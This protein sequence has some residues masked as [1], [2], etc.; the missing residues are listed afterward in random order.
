MADYATLLDDEI[1]AFIA[2]TES[3][4]P[5]DAVTLSIGEQRRVYDEMCRAFESGAPP[6]VT[7]ADGRLAGPGGHAIPVRRYAPG[8]PGPAEIV[9]FHGGGFVVG[10]LHSHDEICADLAA[11]T[12]C[13]LTAVAYRL[14]PEAVHPAAFE[15]CRAAFEAVAARGRPVILAGDSAG[16]NL[17]AAVSHAARR[18]RWQPAGQ[19]LIYPGL[20][21][22][23][24]AGSCLA[25]AQAPLLTRADLEFYRL[26]RTGGREVGADPTLAPLQDRD[27]SGLPP[28]VAFGAE[29]DP[30]CDD[31]ATYAAAI[32][33][34]GGR[35]RGFVDRGLVHGWLR[36]RRSAERARAAFARIVAATAALARGG[37]PVPE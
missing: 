26:I 20:G 13:A 14:A 4:Y 1:R 6:G 25:H 11:G 8:A 29:C 22:D 7:A 32:R 23:M 10:G 24:N 16:G 31:A 33:A 36:A 37:W 34:A 3:F 19:V 5:P 35:A 21:G 15:D 30:L 12:G 18:G 17:A 28:T 2:R 9:Y 27:F